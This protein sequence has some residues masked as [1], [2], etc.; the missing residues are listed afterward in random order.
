[1]NLIH[2]AAHSIRCENV[3]MQNKKTACQF[4]SGGGLKSS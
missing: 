4:V 3:V 2:C 1:M